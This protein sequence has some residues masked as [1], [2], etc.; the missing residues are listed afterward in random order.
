[1]KNKSPGIEEVNKCGSKNYK[2]LEKY[3]CISLRELY[4][5]TYNKNRTVEFNQ[6]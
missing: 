6:Y 1:M 3:T 5:G 4:L 2:I